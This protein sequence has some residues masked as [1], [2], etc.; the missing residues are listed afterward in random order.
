DRFS[1]ILVEHRMYPGESIPVISGIFHLTFVR[2][3]GAAFGLLA[4]QR[5]LFLV[6]STVI[7]VLIL[8]FIRR[9]DELGWLYRLVF[10]LVLG[11]AAGNLYDRLLTGR[12]VDFLDF[13]VW[14][15]FNLADSAIVIAALLLAYRF[16]FA[17]D[18]GEK[19]SERAR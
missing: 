6:T 15:V 4:E 16:I 17:G 10:G 12:V 8:V 13:R 11:G 1:K 2:N 19:R 7:I 9:L 14:P 3:P 5:G 18:K